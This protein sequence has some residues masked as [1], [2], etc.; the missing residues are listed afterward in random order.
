MPWD[1]IPLTNKFI[2]L[3][4]N[5]LQGRE[6]TK[7]CLSVSHQSLCQ[8]LSTK[9]S[10]RQA[11]W[12]FWASHMYF[13]QLHDW[14]CVKRQT[15]PYTKPCLSLCIT[16]T[17]IQRS[18]DMCDALWWP[19]FWSM[20]QPNKHTANTISNS[21]TIAFT[22]RSEF[23]STFSSPSNCMFLPPL[24]HTLGTY[25]VPVPRIFFVRIRKQVVLSSLA[26][27]F[28]SHI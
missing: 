13:L 12:E 20:F 6:W 14:V 16:T 8:V 26:H 2:I 21:E 1:I 3:S 4:E 15:H 23:L 9:E 17:F 11:L 22:V 19:I 27:L 10:N 24:S 5:I 18:S 25:P 28:M 7:Q